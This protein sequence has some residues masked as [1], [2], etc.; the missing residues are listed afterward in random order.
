MEKSISDERKP[1]ISNE[2]FHIWGIGIIT[3]TIVFNKIIKFIKNGPAHLA[4]LK[5]GD[6]I[7]KINNCDINSDII[8]LSG[9][10]NSALILTVL[11]NDEKLDFTIRRT[12]TLF[13]K[14]YKKDTISI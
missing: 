9:K 5:S 4:G 8:N 10:Y 6:L 13:K 2:I 14:F 12:L 7:I 11:R 3:D 1:L